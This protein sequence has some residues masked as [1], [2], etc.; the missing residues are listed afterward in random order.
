[1]KWSKSNILLNKIVISSFSIFLIIVLFS[2]SSSAT[3]ALHNHKLVEIHYV[4]ESDL[5]NDEQPPLRLLWSRDI[6]DSKGD[7]Y[8]YEP[9]VSNENVYVL[10]E[11]WASDHRDAL[12]ALNPKTGSCNWYKRIPGDVELNVPVIGNNGIYVSSYRYS[13]DTCGLH[14]MDYNNGDIK[15]NVSFDSKMISP[16]CYSNGLIF[17]YTY[18]LRNWGGNTIEIY[19]LKEDTGDIYWE[20]S[21]KEDKTHYTPIQP[22]KLVATDGLLYVPSLTYRIYCLDSRSGEDI[23]ESPLDCFL[24]T[25][26]AVHDNTLYFGTAGGYVYALDARYG[27]SK[28]RYYAGS[29]YDDHFYSTPIVKDGIL[30]SGEMDPYV[31]AVDAKT[32]TVM[33][34]TKVKGDVDSS[35]VLYEDVI[36]ASSY[37]WYNDDTG[38]LYAFNRTTGS[39]EWVVDV[40]GDPS[41]PVIDDGVIYL[42]TYGDIYAFKILEKPQKVTIDKQEVDNQEHEESMSIFER[43]LSII[44]RLNSKNEIVHG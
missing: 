9:I 24:E 31:T 41:S 23:W 25:N 5:S 42:A 20:R 27:Y 44:F 22:T 3:W 36:Y 40:G 35:P 12:V 10:T 17:V 33:W 28:W 30:Y 14:A 38:Y 15:W 21:I 37:D 43:I 39:Q 2:S 26:P 32:G 16:P 18:D 29:G 34:E 1:M 11:Q 7:P 13:G 6:G 19:A 4:G 8:Y